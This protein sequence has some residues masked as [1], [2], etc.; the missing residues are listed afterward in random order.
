MTAPFDRPALVGVF[1]QPQKPDQGGPA[2]TGASAPP[3]RPAMLLRQARVLQELRC[4]LTDGTVCAVHRVI[5]L[6]HD[7]VREFA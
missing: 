6:A 3:Y 7:L 2:Q 4:Y 1:G 5:Q